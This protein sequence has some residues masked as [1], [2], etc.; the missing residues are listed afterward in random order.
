MHKQFSLGKNDDIT[1]IEEDIK[2]DV[3][4][5]FIHITYIYNMCTVNPCDAPWFINFRLVYTYLQAKL[6]IYS[7]I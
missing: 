3:K 4:L 5:S 6:S 7:K 2:E 1:H